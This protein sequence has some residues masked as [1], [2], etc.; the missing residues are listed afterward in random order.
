MLPINWI[1][2]NYANDKK[3]DQKLQDDA[4]IEID[5]INKDIIS[6]LIDDTIEIRD[7][8]IRVPTPDF[9]PL[10]GKMAITDGYWLFIKPN[11]FTTG[12]H[13]VSSF[14]SCRSGKI[15]VNMKYHLTVK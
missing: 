12:K 10:N 5:I 6:V 14:G 4:K 2:I 13:T 15:Q 9:F 8:C 7:Q 3:Y 1:G 11:S